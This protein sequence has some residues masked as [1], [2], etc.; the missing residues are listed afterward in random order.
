MNV[1]LAVGIH[2]IGAGDLLCLPTMFST[3]RL[4]RMGGG[5]ELIFKVVHLA[6][7]MMQ[8]Q[9]HLANKHERLLLEAAKTPV[10]PINLPHLV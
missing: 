10:W 8:N 6:F 9:L 7:I 4:M 5:G 3:L 2:R 1:L